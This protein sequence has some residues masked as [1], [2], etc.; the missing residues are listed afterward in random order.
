MTREFIYDQAPFPSC[1]C[2]TIAE[3]KEGLVVSWFG[4]TDEG[5]TDVCIY[6]SRLEGGRWT[7]PAEV[8]NG[9]TDAKRFPSWNPVLFQRKDGPLFLF[10]KIGPSPD[11]WWGFEM[12]STD[13]GKTWSKAVGLAPGIMGPVRN[14]PLEL[15]NGTIVSPTS[16]ENPGGTWI[17]RVELSTDHGKTWNA[18]PPINDD[19]AVEVIQPAL[20]AWPAGRIQMLCRNRNRGALKGLII[21]SWSEDGGKTWSPM[22]ATKLPNPNSGIAATGLK[23]GRGILIYNPTPRGRTPLNVAVSSDGKTWKDV[24]V[25]EDGPGE[26]SYPTA[27]Q[28]A[29]GKV[30]VVYTWRREQIRHVVLDPA[31]L[32]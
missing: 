10:Y 14:P 5:K 15:A 9:T 20:V 28:A 12:Q 31:K 7:E 11:S 2:S 17:A 18:I 21:E 23:D 16:V 26:Y 13:G 32:Q 30:H 27:I 4:G 1:H 22:K 19:K 6:V 24:L 3:T 25:L 29:D 8:A